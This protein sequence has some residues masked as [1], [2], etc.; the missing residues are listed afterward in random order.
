MSNNRWSLTNPFTPS[1]EDKFFDKYI[2][3]QNALRLRTVYTASSRPT[4]PG[5][6]QS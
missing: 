3:E 5:V 4:K 1:I 6:Y 2:Q